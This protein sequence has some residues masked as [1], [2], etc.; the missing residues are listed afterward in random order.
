ME[1]LEEQAVDEPGTESEE[2]CEQLQLDFEETQCPEAD[3][4]MNKSRE[5]SQRDKSPEC[6]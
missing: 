1:D 4:L 2:E 5:Y 3:S 6:S